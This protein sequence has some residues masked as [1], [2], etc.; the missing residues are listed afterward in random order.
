MKLENSKSSPFWGVTNKSD[1]VDYQSPLC[2]RTLRK[3]VKKIIELVAR[4]REVKTILDV[5]CGE[6]IILEELIKNGYSVIGIDI[7]ENKIKRLKNEKG[8]NNVFVADLREFEISSYDMIIFCD[9]LRYMVK[10]DEVLKLASSLTKYILISETNVFV[11]TIGRIITFRF[12]W[13]SNHISPLPS[14]KGYNVEYRSR[15]LFENYWV[16]RNEET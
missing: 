15:G 6:G 1:I 12:L 14:L 10:P 2:G 3:K 5:G 11:H 9:T 8:W 7:D 16:I 13:R 4:F